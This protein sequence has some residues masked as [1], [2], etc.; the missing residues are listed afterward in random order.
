[1]LKV[2]P[3]QLTFLAMIVLSIL[4]PFIGQTSTKNIDIDNDK[5]SDR[6][7]I[8]L[9]T[10]LSKDEMPAVSFKHDLH[11]QALEGKCAACHL[12]KDNAFVFKFKRTNEKASMDLYHAE[13]IAC[14]VEKK[15]SNETFGPDAAECRTCH[16]PDKSKGSSWEEIRFDKSLHFIH[17]SSGQIKGMDPSIK[18]NC[19]RC[20]HKYNEKTKEIFYIKG[21]EESCVYCHKPVKQNDIRSIQEASHDSCVKCHQTFKGQNIA[22]GPTTCEACHDIEKQK[23]IKKVADIPRLKRNQPDEV[24]ITGWETGT[25]TKDNYMKAVA[26]DHKSH[27]ATAQSC[28]VCHHETLKKCNDCHGTDGGESKG[29]FISLEQAMHKQDSTKS[30]IGCHK[31]LTKNSDCAGC[32]FQAPAKKDYSDSCKTCHS[33]DQKQLESMEPAK[34]A[35]MALKNLSTHYKSVQ[36]DKIP[37]NIVIDVLSSE[38]KPSQFPH[39]K[40]VQAIFLRVEQSDMAKVFHGDQAE[41]C[42]GCH[43]NSPKT[44]EPPKCASCHSKKGPDTRD[45]SDGRPGL[46]GAYHGQCIT[47]HQKMEVKTMAATDC[48][49]C[50]EEK[51]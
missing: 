31:E 9:E 36:I 34:A 47:C 13:C 35:K 27:E 20:H 43:H 51:K 23:K 11:T 14:H 44:L 19:S 4:F 33:L 39:R 22:A 29:G 1:M 3:F 5:R 41:L 6:I 42:M 7:T 21:E 17:Q 32:H 49:K 30:C 46:K 15:A 25:Q 18:D 24:A 8:K 37:E 50:H 48:A 38:Y 16:I 40:M 45:G 26:F 28:K 2:K 10:G 12:E